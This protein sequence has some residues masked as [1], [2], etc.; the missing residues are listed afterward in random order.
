MGSSSLIICKERA[1]KGKIK[2]RRDSDIP[3]N[4]FKERSAQVPTLRVVH[5][6]ITM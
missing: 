4:M 1:G 2:E 3:L 6:K 5:T